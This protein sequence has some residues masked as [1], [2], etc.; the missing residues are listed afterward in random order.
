[1]VTA[2]QDSEVCVQPD[3]ASDTVGSPPDHA[4]DAH[5][6]YVPACYASSDDENLLP[7]KLSPAIAS[8]IRSIEAMRRS[9]MTGGPIEQWRFE[10][11]RARFK[12]L[13]KTGA[14]DPAVEEVIRV[15]QARVTRHEQAAKAA[16]TIQTILAA[17]HR[18]DREVAEL[19]RQL[20]SATAGHFHSRVY[21]GVGFMQ[22]SSQEVDGRKVFVLIGKNGATVAFLDIPPGLDP[23]PLLA[24][25]VGVCGV[26]HY[27]EELHSRLI[28]VRDLESIESRR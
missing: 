2:Q 3:E 15:R 23:G 1:V 14:S 17:S 6:V 25:R 12:A 24:R 5:S 4:A 27:D 11:V 10:T 13:L 21:Q 18:R 26:A 28:T 19:E 20:Q 7:D 16:R 8:E 22:P 9:I